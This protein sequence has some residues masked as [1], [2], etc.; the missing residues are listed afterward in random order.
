[1]RNEMIGLIGESEGLKISSSDD[2]ASSICSTDAAWRIISRIDAHPVLKIDHRSAEKDLRDWLSVF[3]DGSRIESP[4]YLSL[5]GFGAA[6][7]IQVESK[8]TPLAVSNFWISSSF[9]ELVQLDIEQRILIGLTAEE[10]TY[11]IRKEDIPPSRPKTDE[12]EE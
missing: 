10:Y 2:N 7:W 4:I 12:H 1:M 6:G 8:N 5:G 11:E 9:R 3:L